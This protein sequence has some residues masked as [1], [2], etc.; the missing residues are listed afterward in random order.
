MKSLLALLAIAIG[1][2]VIV[3]GGIDD[4]P[5]AQ[6]L[7]VCSSSAS[8]LRG[9]SGAPRPSKPPRIQGRGD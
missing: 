3:L 4:A 1:L 9:S 6:I 2:A 7:G 8:E 5:G